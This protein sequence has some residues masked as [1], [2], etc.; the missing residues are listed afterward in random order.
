VLGSDHPDVAQSLNNLAGVLLAQGEPAAAR[1]LFERALAIYEKV[2]GPDHPAISTSLNILAALLMDQG[3]LAAAQP[4]IEK[5]AVAIREKAFGSAHPDT[6]V[7]L[8]QPRFRISAPSRLL[9]RRSRSSRGHWPS[10]RGRSARAIPDSATSLN[11]LAGLLR[12]QGDFVAAR[13]L[14]ERALTIHEGA[15]GPDNPNTAL[16]LANLASLLQA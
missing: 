7:G 6:A 13:P 9:P 2:L 3:D 14:Y 16:S 10:A 11:N 15:C 12:D 1:P 4:L 8:G 5:R